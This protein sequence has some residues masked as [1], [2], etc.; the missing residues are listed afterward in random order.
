[1]L[2][3]LSPDVVEKVGWKERIS[4]KIWIFWK[5]LTNNKLHPL[6]FCSSVSMKVLMKVL[7]GGTEREEYPAST[8]AHFFRIKTEFA[9][10][11]TNHITICYLILHLIEECI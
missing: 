6:L 11:N 3:S 2:K 5:K 1:M 9:I 8:K 4:E 7:K 10:K